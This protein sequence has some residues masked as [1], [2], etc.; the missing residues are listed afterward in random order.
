M[1]KNGFVWM[2]GM[3]FFLVQCAT[4]PI[5]GRKQLLI[6]PESEMVAMSLTS[7][8]DFLKENK[9]STNVA[10]SRKLKEL[11]RSI[12]RAVEAYLK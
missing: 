2:L 7:Y 1:K 12:A 5:T 6:M 3:A 11:G 8:N 10:D 4:V 9:L